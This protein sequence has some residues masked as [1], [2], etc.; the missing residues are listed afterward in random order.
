MLKLY[1]VLV[2][3]V[4][5]SAN[6]ASFLSFL[7]GG[8]EPLDFVKAGI[9]QLNTMILNKQWDQMHFQGFSFGSGVLFFGLSE[10]SVGNFSTI[11]L[12]GPN[13]NVTQVDV[14]SSNTYLL[15]LTIGFAELYSS[16]GFDYNLFSLLK[17]KGIIKLS[18][19][20]SIHI[21]GTI[22]LDIMQ[23]K[24]NASLEEAG[25]SD[26][27]NMDISINPGG[28]LNNFVKWIAQLAYRFGSSKLLTYANNFIANSINDKKFKEQVSNAFC[29]P[30][31]F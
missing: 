17:S 24:C 30:F 28:I 13:Q 25:M 9:V 22:Y 5:G 8:S 26:F 7:S 19:D 18:T 6:G 16:M 11:G 4:L 29:F 12:Q 2:A 21:K 14:D 1:I 31:K 10:G 3:A 27:N 23:G 15:D 20:I